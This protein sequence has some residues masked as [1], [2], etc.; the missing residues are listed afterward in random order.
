MLDGHKS[1][2]NISS[3]DI[4]R[5]NQILLYALPSNTTHLL[6]PYK[7]PFK[8]LKAEY[9]NASERYRN[10]NNGAIVTKYTFAK[11]FGEAH[12]KTYTSQAITNAFKF[13]GAWPV[14]SKAI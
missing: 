14:N 9:D 6:Q 11:V 13:T 1:H 3:L 8:K 4:C 7:L 2:I 5:A 10:Q 12:K